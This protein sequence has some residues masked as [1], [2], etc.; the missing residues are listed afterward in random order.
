MP[1]YSTVDMTNNSQG[2]K[3]T[4]THI[5]QYKYKYNYNYNLGF[6]YIFLET[7]S[8]SRLLVR[9]VALY[10]LFIFLLSLCT[11]MW[12]VNL[13]YNPYF[14][15]SLAYGTVSRRLA[16]FWMKWM[17]RNRHIKHF[18]EKLESSRSRYSRSHKK[19]ITPEFVRARSEQSLHCEP[20]LHQ[21]VKV[22]HF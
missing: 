16:L 14:V 9:C 7:R 1:S 15:V 3:H 8:M 5:I 22:S 11:R 21:P 19:F 10:N 17:R 6:T 4:H 13:V 12:V 2:N 18:F 20:R